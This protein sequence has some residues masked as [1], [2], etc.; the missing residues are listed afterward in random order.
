MKWTLAVVLAAGLAMGAHAAEKI[1][2][3]VMAGAEEE[4][5]QEAVK[6]P[7]GLTIIV[8]KK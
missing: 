8:E 7:K 1:K 3:G 5:A 6:G 2:L 4:I